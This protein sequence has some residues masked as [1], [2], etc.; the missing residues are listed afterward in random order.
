MSCPKFE[1]CAAPICPHDGDYPLRSY[2]DGE[3]VCFYMME[4]VKPNGEANLRGAIG[5]I[6]AQA[7]AEATKSPK[8]SYGP[9]RRRLERASRTPSRLG[10]CDA[11]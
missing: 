7:I 6:D 9:I 8:C 10:V 3:P 5:G 1:S 4:Y 2:L 11:E